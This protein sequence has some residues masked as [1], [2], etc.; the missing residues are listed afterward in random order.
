MRPC[1]GFPSVWGPWFLASGTSESQAPL[2]L[3]QSPSISLHSLDFHI[4]EQS[5]QSG[6]LRSWEE[7]SLLRELWLLV[8]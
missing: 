8:L 7:K 2:S 3:H 5:S 4:P 6:G 1:T